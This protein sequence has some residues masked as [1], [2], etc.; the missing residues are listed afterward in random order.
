[1]GC[2]PAATLDIRTDSIGKQTPRLVD[3]TESGQREI[4]TMDMHSAALS[5]NPFDNDA[6][7]EPESADIDRSAIYRDK[8]RGY[9]NLEAE[10]ETA[11]AKRWR[12]YGDFTARTKLINAHLKLA[13]GMASKYRRAMDFDDLLSE[14]IIGLMR[15]TD[16]FDPDR[17]TRF[18]T[19]ARYWITAALNQYLNRNRSIVKLHRGSKRLKD[20]SL[21]ETLEGEDGD[22]DTRQ[23][24]LVDEQPDPEAS[25]VET[26]FRRH[27]TR[28][29]QNALDGRDY[30]IV[31]ARYL[32]DEP[33][34]REEL[35]SDLGVSSERIRQIEMRSLAQVRRA[36]GS[37]TQG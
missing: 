17:G 29:A 30:Q 28:V 11:L 10:E 36:V 16:A 15:A 5:S 24:R 8:I 9:A 2:E 37:V 22:A 13:L 35:S 23:D 27:M 33:S 31:K 6:N 34:T 1:V 14:A 3:Q 25:L 21:N 32:A 4:V 18:A 19:C 12:E 20:V 7:D 26:D